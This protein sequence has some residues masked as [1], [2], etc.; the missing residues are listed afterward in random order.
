MGEVRGDDGGA[1]GLSAL[2]PL[3]DPEETAK[4]LN[5]S[6]SWLAK[7]R[8]KTGEGPEFVKIGRAVRYSESASANSFCSGPG[9]KQAVNECRSQSITIHH[10]YTTWLRLGRNTTEYDLYILATLSQNTT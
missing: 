10:Q 5:L 6:P 7:A 1:A 3:L 8:G 4:I 9:S 2:E